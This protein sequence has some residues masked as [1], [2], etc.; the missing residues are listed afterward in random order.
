M[1]LDMLRSIGAD[2]VID[3]KKEDFTTNGKQYDLILDVKTN[4]SLFDITRALKSNGIYVTVG[5]STRRLLQ[6]L[7][8]SPWM[9]M[10]K[11]KKIGIVAL[12]TNKDL[13]YMNELFDSGKVIPVIDGHYKLEDVAAAM[14]FYSTAAHKGKIVISIDHNS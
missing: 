3:Y 10:A 14:K 4:R 13:L 9:Q 12:K 5:G 2:H 1:K 7:I 6:A 8:V 11:N